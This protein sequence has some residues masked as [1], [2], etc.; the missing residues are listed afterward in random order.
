[1]DNKLIG[2]KLSSESASPWRIHRLK[3]SRRNRRRRVVWDKRFIV[4]FMVAFDEANV[5]VFEVH[6]A[7][8]S[9]WILFYII[10]KLPSPRHSK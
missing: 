8:Y 2:S 3:G 4:V 9:D 10:G 7:L 6:V 1:M 5:A